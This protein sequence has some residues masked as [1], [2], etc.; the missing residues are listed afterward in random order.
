MKLSMY[1]EFKIL[2]KD[3]ELGDYVALNQDRVNSLCPG[4]F[5]FIIGGSEIPFD[6]EAFACNER[7]GVFSYE[8]GYGAVFNSF[9]LDDC[10]DEDYASLGLAR[11]DITPQFLASAKEIVEFHVNYEDENNEECDMGWYE[12]NA[13]P[14]AP[15]KLELLKI[16]FTDHETGC[17]YAVARGVINEFNGKS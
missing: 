14:D 10:Y 13:K 12:D 7:E 15:I 16:V 6:F 11:E 17:E 4:G 9:E 1:A 5:S 2:E 3:E 8:S